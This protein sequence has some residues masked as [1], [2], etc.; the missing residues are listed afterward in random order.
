MILSAFYDWQIEMIKAIQSVAND[1]LTALV[2]LITMIGEEYVAIVVIMVIYFLFNKKLA[3]KICFVICSSMTL[4]GVIKNFVKEPR[5]YE[6]SSDVVN[7]RKAG[8]YSFPSG[9]SQM[10]ASF[11]NTCSIEI[12]KATNKKWQYIVS[13]ILIVLVMF[14]RLYLGQHFLIDVVC[15][16][17][18]G[19]GCSFG[20]TALYDKY[21]KEGREL[22]LMNIV[23]LIYVPFFIYFLFISGQ[24]QEKG[25]DFF[26]NFGLF[27]GL[28][29]AIL[30]EK[31]FV[32]FDYNVSLPKKILRLVGCLVV[33]L[34]IKEGVGALFELIGDA[35]VAQG[36]WG[37]AV[38]DILH[39]IRY[40]LLSF[41]GMGVYPLIFKKLKF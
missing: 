30:F 21:E 33:V 20:L 32:N 29:C 18:L 31:K 12:D 35:C 13:S 26:K 36:L 4:N 15:G 19:I 28:P 22:M 11:L 3:Q 9:H 10:A 2:S 37:H 25:Y 14:T 6:M 34:A 39:F 38:Y 17:A 1:F 7:Y 8:G 16:A 24:N 5:P 41:V 40:A 23:T 27:F